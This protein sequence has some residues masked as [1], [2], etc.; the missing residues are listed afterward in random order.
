MLKKLIKYE[1]KATARLLLPIYILLII[2]ALINR[3]HFSIDL[4]KGKS[5]STVG[6]ASRSIL[7]A[8]YITVMIAVFVITYFIIS[9]RIYKN[10]LGYEGYLMNTIPVKVS[11]IL[12]SKIIIGI[13]WIFIGVI[14][15]LISIFI[16]KSD[17]SSIKEIKGSL[18]ES[19]SFLQNKLGIDL[20]IV[21]IELFI[22]I[23]LQLISSLIIIICSICIGHLFIEKRILASFLSYICITL[24]NSSVEFTFQLIFSGDFLEKNVVI[25]EMSNL[26]VYIPD[27]KKVLIFTII[28]NIAIVI[29][30]YLLSKVIIE[31]KLNLQ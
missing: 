8:T 1:F 10:L 16:L 20:Y 13:F 29:T 26:L 28:M 23:V 5:I 11:T 30:Y 21:L 22:V 31:K 6:D 12:N 25:Y 2:I 17:E 14:T 15:S 27:I 3:T 4:F 18:I 19:I 24:I 9:Q 7:F